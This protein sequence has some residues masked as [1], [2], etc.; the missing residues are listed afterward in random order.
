MALSNAQRRELLKSEDRPAAHVRRLL[1]DYLARTGLTY[2]D[3]G[4]RINY[5]EK[6]LSFFLNGRY[7]SIAGTSRQ[8]CA[9][10]YTFIDKNPIGEPTQNEG[11]LYR[12]ENVRLLEKYFHEALN[13]SQAYFI[14]GPPG[15]QKS[16]ILERLIHELNLNELAK[17]NGAKAFYIYC[18][19]GIRPRDLMK[20][21][22]EAAGT[23]QASNSIDRI[24]RNFRFDMRNRKAVLCFDEAQ[25]LNNECL[26]I[27]RELFDRPPHCGL[28]F[29]GSHNL[30]QIFEQVGLEQ[31]RSR[32]KA[33]K[34]LPGISLEEAKQIIVGELGEQPQNKVLRL[35]GASS[36]K[37]DRQGKDFTY[38][39]A[40]KLFWA[41][42]DIKESA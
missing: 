2:T 23:S 12:T 24:L 26:E 9:A 34:P 27:V 14:Y 21:I 42:R 36:S 38:I 18:R 10:I 3:F 31:W 17:N 25:H 7:E 29:A 41:L 16:F 13:K 5:S 8:L 40:R 28:L 33:G 37:D 19:I 4:R 11:E 35:I 32:I 39:S 15:T 20:R 6:S 22:A 30:K 1:N